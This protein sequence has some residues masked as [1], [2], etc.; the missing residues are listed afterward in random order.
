MRTYP[1]KQIALDQ[2]TRRLEEAKE[3][4]STLA[5]TP[6][7][8]EMEVAWSRFLISSNGVYA[9]VE[10]AS[11]SNAKS[12]EWYRRKKDYRKSDPLL[13]YLHQARNS[14]EHSVELITARHIDSIELSGGGSYT[15][16]GKYGAN[17]GFFTVSEGPSPSTKVNNPHIQLSS[18]HDR[19]K[20]FDPPKEHMG[21]PITDNSVIGI[22][23]LFIA[24]LE[25]P[26]YRSY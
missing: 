21:Q 2:A 22:A 17:I 3:A 19:S 11:K 20:V 14:D 9:K 24:Y 5:R 6:D 4:I 10:Q 8:R 7:F 25:R 18:V 1:I 15:V 26:P 12:K 13:L 23:S 16:D